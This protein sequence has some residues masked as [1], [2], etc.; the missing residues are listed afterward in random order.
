MP[1]LLLILLGGI[2][3]FFPIKKT[4]HPVAANAFL[5]P[6]F[7]KVE[8]VSLVK[9][10]QCYESFTIKPLSQSYYFQASWFSCQAK[11]IHVG[12]VLEATV[13]LKPLHSMNSPGSFD[14]LQWAEQNNIVAQ[15]TIKSA[16]KIDNA[17][18]VTVNM[19]RLR[20]QLAHITHT[21][22]H[23]INVVAV[24]ESLTLGI[25][26]HLSWELLQSFNL[27]GT[28][29]LLSISGSHIA[30]VAMIAYAIFFS[31]MRF[32][33]IWRPIIN[34][35][36]CAIALSVLVIG[37]YVGLSGEQ[38]PT[39]RALW[40]ALLGLAA[41][42]FHRYSSLMNR[43]IVA[44]IVVILMD[45]SAIYSPSFY[46]SFYAVFL[47]AYH[48]LLVSRA[49]KKWRSYLSLNMLLLIG[50]IPISLFFFS[51]FAF[52]SLFANLI[53]IPWVGFIILPLAILLQ[54]FTFF[55]WQ[56]HFLWAFLEW[57]T[58]GFLWVLDVFSEITNHVPGM[59]LTGHL[60]LTSTIILSL[61]ILLAFLPRGTPGKW[62]C[63]LA[64]IPIFLSRTE[65]E[66]GNAE[67]VFLNVGQ[68]L[69]V[70][71]K[72]HHHLLVYDTGPKFFTG[73]DVA[74]SIIIPYFYYRGWRQVDVLMVSHGDADHSGG[75]KT[76]RKFFPARQVFSSDLQKVPGA[77]LCQRGQYWQWDGVRFEV[78]Y[79]DDAHQHKGNNSSCVLKVTTGSASMLLTGDIERPA[80]KYLVEHFRPELRSAIIS[81]PHHGSK[82]SSSEEFLSAVQP[83]YAVFSYGFLNRFHF[84]SSLVMQRYGE[85]KI[86]PLVTE[87]G[88]VF[89]EIS[90]RGVTIQN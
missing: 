34:A 84:P 70:L 49:N 48:Q 24:I 2:L 81:V 80:E 27:S 17:R 22:L 20:E 62:L 35:H 23:D 87:S 28:R 10:Q 18:G 16:K 68:G 89:V 75:A 51:Q 64:L 69:S 8:V 41:I 61:L 29:H 79:P 39:L 54:W 77:T 52:V 43:I 85:F 37:F 88:P 78:L 42:F 1:L 46:L 30:M 26:N 73:G 4:H 25:S 82:T 40:M 56:C 53:A 11:E 90:P 32:I 59:F 9:R 58:H 67:V 86:A 71:V 47:I 31:L 57:T 55:G 65:P 60:S 6:I 21:Q 44:A 63:L 72:T 13:I 19:Q 14:A 76:L 66:I 5:K 50:L 33:V 36:S 12:D 74:Q 3:V 15:A 45:N 83:K 38:T 7:L